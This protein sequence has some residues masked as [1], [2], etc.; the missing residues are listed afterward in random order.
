MTISHFCTPGY[1]QDTKAEMEKDPIS[2]TLDPR[3]T[4]HNP[5][6]A[7]IP[8]CS[9][10]HNSR[11]RPPIVARLPKAA[12]RKTIGHENIIMWTSKHLKSITKLTKFS[13]S[14]FHTFLKTLG[15]PIRCAC[16]WES[17]PDTCNP[18]KQ[19]K[20]ISSCDKETRNNTGPH[21]HCKVATDDRWPLQVGF[22][23][24][25]TSRRLCNNPTP[26]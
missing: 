17:Q 16:A 18:Q 8:C 7:M 21:K 25:T 24:G 14:D 13:K 1:K 5:D 12:R 20:C 23:A 26:E 15:G 2:M 10:I 9:E 4:N 11:F 3:Q 22:W 6:N 19:C